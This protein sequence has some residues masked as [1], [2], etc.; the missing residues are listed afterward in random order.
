MSLTASTI[1][2]VKAYLVELITAVDDPTVLVCYDDP[3]PNQPDDIIAV[4]DVEQ[5][6]APF[7]LVGGGR[8]R[9]AL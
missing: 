2:E 3:G 1:P 6:L 9:L 7:E 5:T 8:T 4:R